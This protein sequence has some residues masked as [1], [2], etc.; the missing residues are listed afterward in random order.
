[1]Y[2]FIVC[3]ECGKCLAHLYDLYLAMR[4]DRI[5]EF[6]GEEFDDINPF[7]I[8]ILETEGLK[9]GDIL[10]DL[11]INKG[12]CRGHMIAQVEISEYTSL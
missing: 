8:S 2:C 1:M 6:I 12:C 3:P 10:D 5:I 11:G 7:F 4:K 9:V